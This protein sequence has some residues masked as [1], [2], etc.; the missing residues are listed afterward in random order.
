ME[1]G[2]GRVFYAGERRTAEGGLSK[3][4]V[5]GGRGGGNDGGGVSDNSSGP[6]GVS[7][8]N[9]DHHYNRHRHRYP[10]A[11]VASID[12]GGLFSERTAGILLAGR[13]DR[14]RV[15]GGVRSR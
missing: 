6:P 14:V 15:R 11:A 3:T 9:H 5:G 8:Y 4:A 7:G 1:R 13:N 2:R 10:S 12:N